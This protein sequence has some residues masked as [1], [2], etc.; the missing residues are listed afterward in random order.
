M[1]FT[2]QENLTEEVREYLSECIGTDKANITA[3]CSLGNLA[4]WDSLK[5]MEVMLLFEEKYGVVPTP[6]N[7]IKMMSFRGICEVLLKLDHI[8]KRTNTLTEEDFVK[9]LKSVGLRKGDAVF[10]QSSIGLFGKITNPLE[11]IRDAFFSVIGEEGTLVVPTF[12]FGFTRGENFNVEKTESETG[13]FSEYIRKSPNSIR[14]SHPPF[15]SIAG[16]GKYARILGDA[17][18]NTSF[19]QTSVFGKMIDLDFKVCMFGTTLKHN[20]FFH[21]VEEQVGAPYRFYKSFTSTITCQGKTEERTYNY[22]ARYSEP[23]IRTDFHRIGE[24]LLEEF[25]GE[26]IFV[27]SGPVYLFSACKF[28]DVVSTYLNCTAD[29]LVIEEDKWKIKEIQNGHFKK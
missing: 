21:Y 19:S 11:T 6:E 16:I 3:D 23:L 14:S 9:A 28:V 2:L 8:Q 5:H 7:V 27:G 1:D 29:Y 26:K 25:E 10:V 20:T 22:Y 24:N 12:N 15:H 13:L 18:S 17:V 4:C